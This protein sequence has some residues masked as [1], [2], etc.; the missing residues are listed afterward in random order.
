[1]KGQSISHLYYKAHLINQSSNS[2]PMRLWRKIKN[3]KLNSRNN[4][5]AKEFTILGASFKKALDLKMIKKIGYRYVHTSP[6][7]EFFFSFYI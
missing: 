5:K 3:Q 6:V 1:M 7:C 2:P 4:V